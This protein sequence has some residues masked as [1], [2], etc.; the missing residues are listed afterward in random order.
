MPSKKISNL[1]QKSTLNDNDLILIENN[2]KIN[3]TINYENLE[4]MILQ[5]IYPIGSM[6]V[7]AVAGNPSETLG[8]GVW[9]QIKDTFLLAAG[10]N[11]SAGAK[12]G[13]SAITLTTANMPPHT[14]TRGTMEITG[15]C[16]PAHSEN[17]CWYNVTGTSGAFYSYETVSN[18]GK[19]QIAGL[20]QANHMLGFQA[21]R[22]W[23]GETSSVGEG[24]PTEIMPPYL[25]VY[26]WQRI[27]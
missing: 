23:T 25:V 21:S 22:S 6:Y 13:N 8:F 7:S 26:V 15:G 17:V 14:H 3:Q 4:K 12:G 16:A 9:T 1:N 20:W 5:R 2:Q 19:P 27:S 24:Q 18:N 10:D 11:Y